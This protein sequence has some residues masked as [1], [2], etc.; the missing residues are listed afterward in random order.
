MKSKC[1]IDLEIEA[2]KMAAKNFSLALSLAKKLGYS[3]GSLNLGKSLLE[4]WSTTF[5]PDWQTPLI[6]VKEAINPITAGLFR[7]G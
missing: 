3:M 1:H 4:L 5:L 6:F 2:S 7:H